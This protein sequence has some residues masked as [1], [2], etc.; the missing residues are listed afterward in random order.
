MNLNYRIAWRN[1]WRN[2]RRTWLT[3][4]SIAFAIFLVVAAMC[5]QAGQYDV[6]VENST[7]M[8]T[9]HIQIQNS[10][11]LEEERFEDT[12]NE[13]SRIAKL[14]AGTEGVSSIAPRAEVFALAS[15]GELSFGIQVHGVDWEAENNT[16]NF[17]KFVSEGRL[18]TTDEEAIMGAILARNLG[19]SIGEEI[20]LLGAAKR[21]GVGAMAVRIV[22]LFETNIADADRSLVWASLASVKEGFGL[23]DEVHRLVIRTTDIN[24]SSEI[25]HTLSLLLSDP[26]LVVRTWKEVL[27]EINQMID[28]DRISA[29]IMYLLLQI[30][31]VFSVVNSFIII[32]F[33]RTKEF[34]MLMA[35]GMKPPQILWLV[36]W[37]A[38]F[39]WFL[40]MIIGVS[41]S[42]IVI[43][44]LSIT[45][46]P[47]PADL[48]ELAQQ[49]YM[50]SR[51]YPG[52]A[53]EAFITSPLILL[54]GTQFAALISSLRILYMR[55][56]EVLRGN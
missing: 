48:V 9:G 50:P 30:I 22:G 27:P 52:F 36:Q 37:E 28:I 13:A 45:G 3:S 23:D 24:A 8:M 4:G 39:G 44:W 55:P 47:L 41:L 21:G 29:E 46:I 34:G 31:V 25:A 54:V 2:S 40:G 18:P 35:I 56:V 20:T 38:F 10:K 49:M 43:Y 11:H 51:L 6:M 17:L 7:S 15:V 42:S 53:I 16:V 5:L 14:V 33:E 32:V 26:R 12:I 19:I 1:L